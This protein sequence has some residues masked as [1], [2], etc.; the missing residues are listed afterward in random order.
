MSLGADGNKLSQPET[1]AGRLCYFS[2][3]T[4]VE[5]G[6]EIRLPTCRDAAGESSDGFPVLDR[7]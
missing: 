6:A 7:I 3:W 1:V 2:E 4:P 5:A